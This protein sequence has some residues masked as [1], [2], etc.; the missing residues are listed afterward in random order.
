MGLF[1][2]IS[3]RDL[4]FDF[5]ASHN[6]RASNRSAIYSSRL[7]LKFHEVFFNRIYLANLAS[8]VTRVCIFQP[9][10]GAIFVI[11]ARSV[12]GCKCCSQYC[13]D[14]G[15]S[16]ANSLWKLQFRF[17][18]E[19][20]PVCRDLWE[21]QFQLNFEGISP[22]ACNA[23][24]QYIYRW[25]GFAP[26]PFSTLTQTVVL[27]L[28]HGSHCSCQLQLTA[29]DILTQYSVQL[30]YADPHWFVE[31]PGASRCAQQ[32]QVFDGITLER[33]DL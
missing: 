17:P 26:H 3:P 19:P 33:V 12:I 29:I 24:I 15:P 18:V 5:A 10:V 9:Y 21:R 4:R 14:P 11:A 16:P 1:I 6:P 32:G 7:S 8:S 2:V 23:G 31:L 20:S 13:L 27:L 30:S 28:R 22:D 25:S